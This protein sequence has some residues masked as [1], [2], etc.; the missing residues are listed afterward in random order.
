MKKTGKSW[1][2]SIWGT[3]P[4]TP[5]E[6]QTV[7]VSTTGWKPV[8]C[9]EHWDLNYAHCICRKVFLQMDYATYCQY[10]SLHFCLFHLDIR[11]SIEN[12]MC[13]STGS[14]MPSRSLA[15][16]QDSHSTLI[17]PLLQ[18]LA[19]SFSSLCEEGLTPLSVQL[20]FLSLGDLGTRI[21]W[22]GVGLSTLVTGWEMLISRWISVQN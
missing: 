15:M 14:S 16:R 1:R 3:V 18:T 21:Q 17:T 4:R 2:S 6:P 8:R 7:P 12:A 9:T 13:S 19:R 5:T 20:C 11:V 22:T 10:R